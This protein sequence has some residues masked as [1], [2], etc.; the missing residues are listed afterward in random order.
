MLDP[1]KE[2]CSLSELESIF[3]LLRTIE[4]LIEIRYYLIKRIG[5]SIS[6]LHAEVAER[7]LLLLHCPVL[8]CLIN[9]F[10]AELVPILFD[11]LCSNVHRNENPYIKLLR[12][13]GTVT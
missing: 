7:A 12:K 13:N 6:S 11:H 3:N 4:P 8:L 9:Q 5:K 1:A 2:V 10:K